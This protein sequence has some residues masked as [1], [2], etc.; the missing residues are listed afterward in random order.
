MV[1]IT[2]AG[3]LFRA[4]LVSIRNGP[5]DLDA[6]PSDEIV[7][8]NRATWAGFWAILCGGQHAAIMWA[9]L[10][11]GS[12]ARFTRARVSLLRKP[13]ARE[14]VSRVCAGLPGTGS[15]TWLCWMA[16]GLGLLRGP[17]PTADHPLP[18]QTAWARIPYRQS[19]QTVGCE[20][21]PAETCARRVSPIRPQW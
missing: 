7:Q 14:C 11:R 9:G 21:W 16:G 8:W 6:D 1:Q 5:E 13:C 20:W 15:R 12:C 4:T 10:G 18:I 17:Y 19:A 3:C 2:F